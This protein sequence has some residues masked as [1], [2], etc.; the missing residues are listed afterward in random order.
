VGDSGEGSVSFVA[1]SG[2]A[3]QDLFHFQLGVCVQESV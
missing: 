1:D 2:L 3:C